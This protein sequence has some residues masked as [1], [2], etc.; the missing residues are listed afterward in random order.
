[1]GIGGAN[2]E[3]LIN[4]TYEHITATVVARLQCPESI[5]QN[6][7][8]V[9][10]VGML[11]SYAV[12]MQPNWY[13]ELAVYSPRWISAFGVGLLCP[14]TRVRLLALAALLMKA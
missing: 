7:V 3:N 5:C 11:G 2:N 6:P 12:G 1:M 10:W 9:C 14:R 4:C 8:L 13:G